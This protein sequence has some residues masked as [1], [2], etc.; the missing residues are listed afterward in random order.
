MVSEKTVWFKSN[1]KKVRGYVTKE[2]KEQLKYEMQQKNRVAYK[3]AKR[4][5]KSCK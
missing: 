2:M 3:K 5:K 1:V 4:R